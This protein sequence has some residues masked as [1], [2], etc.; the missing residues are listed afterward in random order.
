[1]SSPALTGSSRSSSGR[2]FLF[3]DH[4]IE[5]DIRL[6]VTL[7][8]FDAAYHGVFKCN[9]PGCRIM[10]ICAPSAAACAI[11]R[12]SPGPDLSEIF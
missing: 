2:P 5:S 9:L 11:G 6:F 1:M 8:R 7:A 4:P 10:P 12:A 3:A